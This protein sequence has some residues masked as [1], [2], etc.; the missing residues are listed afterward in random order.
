[1]KKVKLWITIL[2]VL[3]CFLA[4]SIAVWAAE[5]ELKEN[6]L[7]KT[8]TETTVYEQPTTESNPIYTFPADS[9]VMCMG[10]Q[11]GDWVKVKNQEIEGYVLTEDVTLFIQEGIEQEFE[12]KKNEMNLLL[13]EITYLQNEK[14][15]KAIWGIIIGVLIISIFAVGLAS[16]ILNSTKDIK[17]KHKK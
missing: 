3:M 5:T 10:S 8:V 14:Q 6:V 9:L 17:K 7:L 1:M 16:T 2:F 4:M 13:A 15:E 12:E 11:D